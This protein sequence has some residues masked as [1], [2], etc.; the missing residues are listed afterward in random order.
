MSQNAIIWFRRDLRLYDNAALFHA[1]KDSNQVFPVFIFDTKILS[2]LKNKKDR[3]IEFILRSLAEIKKTLN[4]NGS[5]LI[6]EMGDPELLIPKLITEYKCNSLYINRDYEKYAQD[7]DQ[8]ISKVLLNQKVTTFT[9]KDQV[10]FESDEI[11]TQ[12][13]NPYTVFTPY[14][15]NHLKRLNE[16]GI[17]LYNCENHKDNFAKF[18]SKALPTLN[19]LGF[20]KTNLEDLDL[21]TGTSGGKNLLE[22]F[23]KNIKNYSINRNFPSIRGVSYLSVHNRFGTLSIR[24]LAKLAIETDND[25]A[26]TWLSELIW[27]DFYFQIIAN[28][29]QVSEKKSFKSQF[30]NLKFENDEK[31]FE[32]W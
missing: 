2:K 5:D 27:R 18:T 17:Q 7:R 31:K 28:F 32:A 11:L 19:D 1:L 6:V 16:Q 21:P 8:K 22:K 10:L 26:S 20:E 3:R 13:N 15:N 12:S 4:E 23:N 25:G 24:H 29:P 30:E 14:K 9:F